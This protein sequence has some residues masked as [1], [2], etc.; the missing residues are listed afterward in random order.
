MSVCWEA[1]G[2][3][4]AFSRVGRW[5]LCLPCLLACYDWWGRRRLD[6]GLGY[7]LS[8]L[9]SARLHRLPLAAAPDRPVSGVPCIALCLSLDYHR[10]AMLDVS[11]VRARPEGYWRI[12]WHE[13]VSSTNDLV[14]GAAALGAEEGLVVGAE[15][16]TAGRGRWG[17]RWLDAP[18]RCLLF[19]VLVAMREEAPAAFV[20]MAAALAVLRAVREAGAV[21]AGYRWPNDVTAG[22]RK[23]AG[24]LVEMT[25]GMAVVGIGVNVCGCAEDFVPACNA[26]TVEEAAG[27]PVS[28]EELL[29]SI[30]SHL[31]GALALLRSGQAARIVEELVAADAL[32]GRQVTV[33]RGDVKVVGTAVGIDEAGRLEVVVDGEVQSLSEGEV[34][35]VEQ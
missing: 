6:H 19:S 34:V 27:R 11:A 7:L 13:R 25:G 21:A 17:R 30:L 16:Q 2:V 12:S 32:V 4:F 1:C 35:R 31:H 18:G 33:A 8:F 14:A 24:V 5:R 3:P 28:R 20:G 26:T 29:G 23:I 10:V 15:T 22:D 9:V